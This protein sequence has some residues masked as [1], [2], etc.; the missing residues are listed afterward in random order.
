MHD[1][2]IEERIGRLER[3]LR[4]WRV[5]FVLAIV[6]A[7]FA[8]CDAP[9]E[10]LSTLDLERHGQRVHV[11]PTEI[12]IESGDHLAIL[13]A[14]HLELRNGTQSTTITAESPEPHS[15]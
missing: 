1:E 9:S 4:L 13:T 12:R 11:D 7:V 10:S 6:G 2:R 8:A 5:A 15:P 3:E 14:E